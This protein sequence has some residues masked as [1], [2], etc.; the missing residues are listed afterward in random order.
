[1]SVTRL[2]ISGLLVAS[3][4]ILAAFTLHGA[5]DAGQVQASGGPPLKPW[6]TNT[7]GAGGGRVAAGKEA[8]EGIKAQSAQTGAKPDV[9]FSDAKS[10][11][12]A[13]ADAKAAKR[14][15]RME[16]QAAEQAQRTKPPPQQAALQWPWSW[17]GN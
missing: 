8:P 10:S 4:L 12:A 2:L 11:N 16:K 13:T 1:M 14:K 17:F 5:F 7:V 9:K 15:R 3:G 6:A